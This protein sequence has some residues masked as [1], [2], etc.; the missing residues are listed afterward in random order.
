MHLL[1]YF[2]KKKFVWVVLSD[3]YVHIIFSKIN[4]PKQ[5]TKIKIINQLN[6][7]WY[8]SINIILFDEPKWWVLYW[9]EWGLWDK[10]LEIKNWLTTGNALSVIS[11]VVALWYKNAINK[12]QSQWLIRIQ[13]MITKLVTQKIIPTKKTSFVSIIG[14]INNPQQQW[15]ATGK[16]RAI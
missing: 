8:G 16:W 11:S 9:R 2:F 5:L 14:G 6:W 13:T 10:K 3:Y 15:L 1:L 7:V 4:K 12:G